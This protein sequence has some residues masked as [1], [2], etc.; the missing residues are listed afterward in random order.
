M[1]IIDEIVVDARIPKAQF[2]CDLKVCKGTCCTLQGAGGAPIE[3]SEIRTIK[4]SLPIVSKYLTK[5]HQLELANH[6]FFYQENDKFAIVSVNNKDCIFSYKENGVAKCSFE[7]AYFNDEITF[8]K[9]ISCHLFPIRIADFGGPLLRYEKIDECT[10]AVNKGK[11][12]ETSL[13]GF[14]R[15][16]LVR[17]YGVQWYERFHKLCNNDEMNS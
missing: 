12:T 10:P 13:V 3:R 5:K 2:A 7:K 15:D 16:A 17:K 14:L 4:K 8:R 9:P 11:K 1:I 6:S